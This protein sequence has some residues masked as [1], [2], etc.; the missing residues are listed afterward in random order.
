MSSVEDERKNEASSLKKEILDRLSKILRSN[1][2]IKTTDDRKKFLISL[3]KFSESFDNDVEDETENDDELLE[4]E[5]EQETPK[6]GS[7]QEILSK[8]FFRPLEN[9]SRSIAN[10]KKP[11]E[12][13]MAFKNFF[14]KQGFSFDDNEIKEIGKLSIVKSAFEKISSLEVKYPR[15]LP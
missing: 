3:A 15:H 10:S 13:N 5:A 6:K 14:E 9:Y 2:E 4:E 8:Y 7:N 12:R 11:S 1:Q